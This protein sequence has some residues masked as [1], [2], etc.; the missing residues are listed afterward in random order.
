MKL[1]IAFIAKAAKKAAISMQCMECKVNVCT[2]GKVHVCKSGNSV[3]YM[4][5]M[6]SN[7]PLCEVDFCVNRGHNNNAVSYC[8]YFKQNKLKLLLDL[9][10]ASAFHH[11]WKYCTV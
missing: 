9:Y 11:I 7:Y 6:C 1:I 10:H 2:L 3:R 8:Y 4:C 5:E